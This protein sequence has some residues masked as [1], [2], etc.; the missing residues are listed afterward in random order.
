MAELWDI[1]DRERNL[2]G[3][4]V[5]RGQ[6]MAPD[7]YHLVVHVWIRNRRGEWLLS[8][9][10]PNKTF[11]LKWEPTGGSVTSGEDSL[12]G[13]LREVREELGLALDPADAVFFTSFRRDQPRWKC[14]GFVDVWVFPWDGEIDEVR[15]QEGE[16]CGAM[17]ADNRK[18][19]QLIYDGEFVK[20]DS[21]PYIHRLID[22][23]SGN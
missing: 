3:R 22:D 7:E 9:R 20:L 8:Q 16:T 15:Y 18:I 1:Y 17:W 23:E 4:T 14:S 10:T 13:A 19:W 12:T 5:E 21:F 11:P 2:T 6:P